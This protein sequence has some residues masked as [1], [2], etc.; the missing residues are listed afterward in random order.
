MK[1]L[2]V[3]NVPFAYHN[4]ML[5]RSGGAVSGGSWLYAAYDAVKED[6]NIELHV[7]TACPVQ[8]YIKQKFGNSVFHI[9]PGGNMKTYN[10]YLKRNR[11]LCEQFKLDIN[12]DIIL[13][14]GTESKLAYLMSE[15]FHSK[16]IAVYIQ[17]VI[18]SIFR[19]YYDG[20]PSCVRR[21][22]IRDFVDLFNRKEQYKGYKE[23]IKLEEKILRNA[24][25]A[26]VENDW[27]E[28]QCKMINPNLRFFRNNLP[29]RT[30]YFKYGWQL[31]NMKRHSIFVNAGGYPI[32]GHH[33][34]FQA[35]AIVKKIYPDVQVRIPGDNY[36]KTY[37]SAK[38]RTG[39]FHWLWQIVKENQLLNN[40]QFVGILTPDEM[41][42]NI[43]CCNVYVMPSVCENHSASL[44]EAMIVGAPCVSSLVGGVGT[45]IEHNINGIIYNSMDYMSLA[46]NIVRVFSDDKFAI[47]LSNN[48]KK[49]ASTR[50]GDFGSEMNYIY[51][52][53]K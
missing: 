10:P 50:Q 21:S 53:V 12:P 46:G 36:L 32:K 33:I 51:K 47:S 23:Q 26:I 27:C 28:D 29:I 43:Q 13:I 17:G 34:L 11:D 5:G 45:L 16:P 40:I 14:W 35:L 4:E 1:V 42:K 31:E 8:K 52:M 49:I 25:A 39:Y 41:A 18:Q 2:W 37:S 19:H 38:Y 3:T 44:I 15:V 7:V 22:T 48:A 20:V 6:M 9:F 24:K 30:D